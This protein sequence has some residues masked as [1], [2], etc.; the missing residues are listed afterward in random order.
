MHLRRTV[1]CHRQSTR[2]S[3]AR[4]NN[5]LT[6]LTY[7][8]TTITII[9]IIITIIIIIIT[10]FSYC[11]D[12]TRSYKPS[13]LYFLVIFLSILLWL[14]NNTEYVLLYKVKWQH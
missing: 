11:V 8:I 6:I 14:S 3:L 4:V 9:T 1:H 12:Y 2:A 5:E 10:K 13:E 7:T